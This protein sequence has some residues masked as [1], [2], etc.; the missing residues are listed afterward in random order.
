MNL[1]PPAHAGDEDEP[2]KQ[3]PGGDSID[4]PRAKRV[5]NPAQRRARDDGDLEHRG[6]PGHGAR[7]GLGRDQQGQK[8]SVGRCHESA[9]D[10]DE[11][12]HGED[13]GRVGGRMQRQHEQP[14]PDQGREREGCE[15]HGAPIEAVGRQAAR[16][17]EQEGGEELRQA[18]H[19]ER[20]GAAGER[21]DLP[22]HGYAEHRD[23]HGR[24]ESRRQK[25]RE[26]SIGRSG[27][28]VGHVGVRSA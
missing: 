14:R 20:E 15:Q 28:C 27:S 18:D 12:D 13:P 11:R 10:A 19:A 26:V 5:E 16:Q 3:E 9:G 7:E 1:P 6:T 17:A 23:R 4:Q 24:T 21:I 2:G 8:R 25:E 22:T